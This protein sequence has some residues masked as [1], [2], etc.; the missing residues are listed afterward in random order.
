MF[1]VRDPSL[2]HQIVITRDGVS[3]ICRRYRV[4]KKCGTGS[5]FYTRYEVF[6]SA[7]NLDECLDAYYTAS[8]HRGLGHVA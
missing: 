4:R 3:C 5:R 7:R 2:P 8:N 1:P 6:A